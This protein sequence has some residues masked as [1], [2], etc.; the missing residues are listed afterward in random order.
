MK[1]N[2][3][4]E[5]RFNKCFKGKIGTKKDFQI[6]IMLAG[7]CKMVGDCEAIHDI[8][9]QTSVLC[10]SITATVFQIKKSDYLNLREVSEESF[11]ELA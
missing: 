4:I 1:N 5:K 11:N 3:K 10:H 2:T 9:S 7:S 8:P 6:S